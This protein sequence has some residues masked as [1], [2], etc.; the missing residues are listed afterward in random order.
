[1]TNYDFNVTFDDVIIL[2]LFQNIKIFFELN[3]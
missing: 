1:M 2:K 3:Y